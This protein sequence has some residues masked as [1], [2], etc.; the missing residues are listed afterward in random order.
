MKRALLF[1]A[2]LAVWMLSCRAEAETY[3]TMHDMPVYVAVGYNTF[4]DRI[5]LTANLCAGANDERDHMHF[6]QIVDAHGN[7]LTGGCWQLNPDKS[8]PVIRFF[9]LN[10]GGWGTWPK[11]AFHA[12][13][14]PQGNN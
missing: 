2:M 8:L 14:Y 13:R 12:P 4:G 1:A 3:P 7:M 5:L 10:G 9:S 11:S 6:Y